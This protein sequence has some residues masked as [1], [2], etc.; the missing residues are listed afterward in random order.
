MFVAIGDKLYAIVD[1]SSI[2]N[3]YNYDKKLADDGYP[4]AT[5]TPTTARNTVMTTDR[6]QIIVSYTISIY[7]KNKTLSTEEATIR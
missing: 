5:I 3:V 6:D 4:Y 2:A 7:V 1:A